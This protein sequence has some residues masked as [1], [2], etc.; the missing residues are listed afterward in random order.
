[1]CQSKKIRKWTWLIFSMSIFMIS[2]VISIIRQSTFPAVALRKL[3]SPFQILPSYSIME[4][5]SSKLSTSREIPMPFFH[6]QSLACKAAWAEYVKLLHLFSN[7]IHS[8]SPPL[9]NHVEVPSM[10]RA[11]SLTLIFLHSIRQVKKRA[12]SGRLLAC[13]LSR[14]GAI[15]T[16]SK[17][18]VPFILRRAWSKLRDIYL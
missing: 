10:S 11:I 2:Q 14:I 3:H 15:F 4:H 7:R 12:E 8:L 9:C 1:M 17:Q 6:H 16:S 18:V 5:L 13:S